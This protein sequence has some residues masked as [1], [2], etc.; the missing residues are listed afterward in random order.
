V[1]ATF[2]RAGIEVSRQGGRTLRNSFAAR[3]LKAGGAIELVGEFMGHR[4]RRSTEHYIP[5][6][7]PQKPHNSD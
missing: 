7:K 2:A 4:R 6:D 1:K 5:T 3:E